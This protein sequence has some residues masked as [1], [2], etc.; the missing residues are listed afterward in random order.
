[1]AIESNSQDLSCPLL[2]LYD[3]GVPHSEALLLDIE[4][5]EEKIDAAVAPARNSA[6]GHWY[7]APQRRVDFYL[8]GAS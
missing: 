3:A 7:L 8:E 2:M 5:A 1:M 6:R 4:E